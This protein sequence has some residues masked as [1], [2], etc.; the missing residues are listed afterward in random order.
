MITRLKLV[1]FK[2]F[3]QLDLPLQ[4]FTVLVGPNGSG[5]TTI[6][7]ALDRLSCV[8]AARLVGHNSRAA[9]AEPDWAPE[10]AVRHG[11]PAFEATAELSSGR[12]GTT[13]VQVVG[14]PGPGG[15]WDTEAWL[16]DGAAAAAAPSGTEDARPSAN[17]E[18]ARRKERLATVTE[19]PAAV[20]VLA[21]SALLQ[22]DPRAAA[23]PS[24]ELVS[25]VDSSGAGLASVLA[26]VNGF[27]PDSFAD[28]S[29]ALREVVPHVVR[30]RFD[31]IPV[32][33]DTFADKSETADA[34]LL[35]T[36][37]APGLRA[38]EAGDGTIQ[39]LAVLTTLLRP[40]N[41]TLL[42]LDDMELGLH[43]AAQ[44][45]FVG[46]LRRLLDRFPALQIVATSH[47]PFVLDCLDYD[48]VCQTVLGPEGEA[49][50]GKLMEHPEYAKWRELMRPGEFWSTVGEKWL[51]ERGAAK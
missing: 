41:P 29:R 40:P 43:P 32:A 39:V 24:R 20:R 31:R 22:L 9:F 16:L 8:A 44:V 19:V 34:I 1:N 51:A 6:L 10:K 5:K 49:I 7:Q 4:R 23:R 46:V 36:T 30:V 3:K 47:S 45:K 33:R 35:D 28:I 2:G 11:A 48:E 37:G 14:E 27:Y 13:A 38:S 15:R 42:L 17:P 12:G 50:A 21:G 25:A 18:D 26:H